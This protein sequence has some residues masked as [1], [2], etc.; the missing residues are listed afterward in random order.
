VGARVH[1]GYDQVY[2]LACGRVSV[3]VSESFIVYI[4]AIVIVIVRSGF[5]REI[6]PLTT[7]K[8]FNTWF[9]RA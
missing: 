2:M 3:C 4:C 5:E 9:N 6:F 7:R 1:Y 8:C